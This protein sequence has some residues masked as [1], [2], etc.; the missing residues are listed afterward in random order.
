MINGMNKDSKLVKKIFLG[1]IIYCCLLFV[2]SCNEDFD[3]ASSPTT[4]EVEEDA[5]L[6]SSSAAHVV[7]RA[8]EKRNYFL[9]NT[10]F[11]LYALVSKPLLAVTDPAYWESSNRVEPLYDAISTATPLG[12]GAI[13]YRDYT[14][15]QSLARFEK[16]TID[17]YGVTF[18]T[19]ATGPVTNELEP[20]MIDPL[21][22]D[23]IPRYRIQVDTEDRDSLP[24]LMRG[25]AKGKRAEDGVYVPLVFKHTASRLR[26]EVLKQ[27]KTWQKDDGNGN[28]VTRD[29]RLNNITLKNLYSEGVL[30][31][32]TGL[33]ELD[34]SAPTIDRVF[35]NNDT[36]LDLSNET[37]V[38]V[39]RHLLIFPSV[40]DANRKI[41]IDFIFTI[42][43]VEKSGSV[44]LENVTFNP[45]YDYLISFMLLN[46]DVQLA[47]FAPEVYEWIDVPINDDDDD[48][49]GNVI[50]FGGVTW[51]D[52]NLGARSANVDKQWDK[53]RGA[54]YQY[55]RSIPYYFDQ[56][57][58]DALTD[59]QRA[60]H[61]GG[62]P[63]LM[64]DCPNGISDGKGFFYTYNEKGERVYDARVVDRTANQNNLAIMPGEVKA[65]TATNEPYS[66][67]KCA[68]GGANGIWLVRTGITGNITIPTS[69]DGAVDGFWSEPEKNPCP[70]GWKIPSSSDYES[71]LPEKDGGLIN[72]NWN[73]IA[74]AT[75]VTR[76]NEDRMF[77][78]IH[79]EQGIYLMKNKG[80]DNAYII[81]IRLRRVLDN[82]N[83]PV[84]LNT[85]TAVAYKQYFEISRYNVTL[86]ANNNKQTTFA[87][88]NQNS[89]QN[90]YTTT[91]LSAPVEVM[92][93]PAYGQIGLTQDD[94]KGLA[95]DGSSALMKTTT[96][97]GQGRAVLGY[98]R[99]VTDGFGIKDSSK[100]PG[101]QIR[102]VRDY[103]AF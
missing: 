85:S 30:N 76:A 100:S 73:T 27:E 10:L 81:R 97:S 91:F 2:I 24:D 52:R 5:I 65:R 66:F 26:F 70:K 83:N 8:G 93:F 78:R 62:K 23:Q 77:G 28:M 3:G 45:N 33:Y 41:E 42:D 13:N 64:G 6:F 89:F 12:E 87:G 63:Q 32:A 14:P 54:Y 55:G 99:A 98:L 19:Q 94:Q 9:A 92:A 46:D 40:L 67:I 31:L 47:I 7:T 90:R 80:S 22:A 88:L 53:C 51:M 25:V 11:R 74:T 16:R 86:D 61:A 69:E 36:G 72:I 35:Y 39:P 50:T 82:Q 38:S 59:A 103:N 1:G 60:L 71:F 43:G 95:D 15:T 84:R 48:V 44:F 18:N 37:S 79:G 21:P 29:I 20:K 56:A 49:L 75:L 68:T 96:P 102:C 58:W 4:T 17:V 101:Q 34:A 57:K